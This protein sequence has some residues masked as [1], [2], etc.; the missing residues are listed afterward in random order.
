[1]GKRLR[2]CQCSLA[3]EAARDIS[4]DDQSQ[5]PLRAGDLSGP[6]GTIMHAHRC[7]EHLTRC[8]IAS[9]ENCAMSA[10]RSSQRQYD[11][12]ARLR[13]RT[14]PVSVDEDGLALASG[15]RKSKS[16]EAS[17]SLRIPLQKARLAPVSCSGPSRD[18][19]VSPA[20]RQ[21][22]WITFPGFIRLCGR[23]PS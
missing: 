2:N 15:A 5:A 23:S 18:E 19:V 8:S 7:P 9:R 20:N 1:M 11:R 3:P 14:R 17:A 22:T 6:W 21:S 4:R 13:E 16:A 10:S 12:S